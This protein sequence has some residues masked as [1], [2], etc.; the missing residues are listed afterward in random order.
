MK[1]ILLIMILVIIAIMSIILPMFLTMWYMQ[2]MEWNIQH[3]A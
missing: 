2:K 1:K 3:I